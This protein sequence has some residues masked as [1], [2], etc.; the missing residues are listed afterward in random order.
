MEATLKAQAFLLVKQETVRVDLKVHEGQVF[1]RT[2]TDGV[3]SDWAP[4]NK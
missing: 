1:F 3:L 2:E 4:L